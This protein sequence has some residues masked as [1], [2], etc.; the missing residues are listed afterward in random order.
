MCLEEKKSGAAAAAAAACRRLPRLRSGRVS[1]VV[2]DVK[3]WLV[4][5]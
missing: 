2:C 3:T 5:G 4:H 1:F